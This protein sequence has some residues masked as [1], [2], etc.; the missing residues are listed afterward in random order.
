[1]S[2]FSAVTSFNLKSQS[3]GIDMLESYYKFWPNE[4][5]LY[6]CLEET[7]NLDNEKVKD[8][9]NILDFHKEIPEYTSFAKKY[10]HKNNSENYRY[11]ALKFAHKIFSIK[12]AIS[13]CKTQYLIWL[14]ADIKTVKIIDN[15]FLNSLVKSNHY[16]SYLGREHV[17]KKSIRYSETGFMIFNLHHESH[18][19]FWS[20][21][22]KMYMGG[23]LFNLDE[24]TDS[25][26]LDHVRKYLETSCKLK[27]INL[28]D[29]G[30]KDVGNESHV[31]VGSI[32]GDYM[33]HKKGPRKFIK[34][35]KEFI[36][37]YKLNL[38]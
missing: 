37:R 31:F 25:W 26:V 4:C 19:A 11:D 32:L 23:E 10:F 12:K 18:E 27:N 24:W 21:I 16:M 33:D 7:P 14:D 8:K 35:S 20:L 6:A 9:I 5:I 15:N 1:M 17:Q 2:S 29:F 30:L 22:D 34:W 28:C 36:R 13:M 3:Y 38:K